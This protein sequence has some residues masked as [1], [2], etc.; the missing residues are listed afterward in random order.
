VKDRV[1]PGLRV[2]ICGLNPSIYSERLGIP[3][4]RP[5]NRFWPAALEAGLVS[6]DRDPDHALA[7][8]GVGWTDLVKRASVAASS[9]SA[10]EY[11]A[12]M[13]RVRRLANRFQPKV[14]CFVGLSGW[15]AA[16]D[17]HAQPGAY[18]FG[19]AVAYVMPN[20]SGLNAHAQHADFVAHFREAL[21]IARDEV[22][23]VVDGPVDP[24]FEVHVRPGRVPG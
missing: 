23:R 17:A 6:R 20:T 4:A 22:A 3:F 1:A 21:R 11:M 7:H 19:P 10:D 15:R 9:L 18:P 8:D 14:V 13:R 12:G 2:I 16:V 24:H 5:G